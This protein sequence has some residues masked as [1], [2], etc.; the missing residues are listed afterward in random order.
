V[1]GTKPLTIDV[2]AA[3]VASQINLTANGLGALQALCYSADNEQILFDCY[4]VGAPTNA[5]YATNTTCVRIVK[6][7]K[8]I[9]YI[10]SGQ[11]VDTPVGT[12][13]TGWVQ[14]ISLDLVTGDCGFG[15][16]MAPGYSVD[17]TGDVNVSG[18]FR[19]GGVPVAAPGPTTQTVVTGS[20]VLGTVYH[21]TGTTP[22][23]CSVTVRSTAGGGANFGEASAYTDSAATPTTI[24]GSTFNGSATITTD[25]QLNFWVLPGNYY[26]VAVVTTTV[27]LSVWTEWN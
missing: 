25:Q 10:A 18:V 3:P 19:I 20:R 6:S 26:K 15:G 16:N 17:V 1:S 2:G 12:T 4:W 23:Y 5:T 9:F 13:G 24:V 14:T 7:G 22:K 8:L 27:T 11:T 21:N